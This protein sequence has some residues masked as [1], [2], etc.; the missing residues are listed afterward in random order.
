[1]RSDADSGSTNLGQVW[2]I[3]HRGASGHAPENT[4]GAFR[5]AAKMG[6]RFIE[7]D[8]RLTRD[9]HVVAVHDATVN[10]TTN[11]RGW[12]SR[13]SLAKIRELDAGAHFA[14]AKRS[15]LAE[16]IPTLEEILGFARE[17]RTGCYLELKSRAR[18]GLEEK[19][20]RALRATKMSSR[21][22]IISFRATTLRTVRDLDPS[23]TT[24]FIVERPTARFIFLAQ[25]IG[26][27]QLLP[28]ADRTTASLVAAARRAKLAVVP[29]TVNDPTS[30]RRLIAAGVQ[31]II[32]NYPDR[33]ALLQQLQRSPHTEVAIRH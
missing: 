1:M 19:V 26:T 8:L 10:R 29:W 27:R 2:N 18:Q 16:R 20:I 17:A 32:T 22:V 11:G 33:L 12:V 30:M 9:G 24:G 25:R 13:M 15:P 14:G 4:L 3:A 23:I 5:L 6:A 21:S 31:G 28:R 7:T